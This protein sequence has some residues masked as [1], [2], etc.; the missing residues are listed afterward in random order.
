MKLNAVSLGVFLVG[1]CF[2]GEALAVFPPARCRQPR[3]RRA[4]DAGVRSG[5]SLVESAWNAVNDCDQVERFAD[6]VMNNLDSIDIPRESSDY[7]LCRVAGIV[8]GAEEVVDH[9]WN[10]CDWEC[11]KEGELMA[12]IGGKLYCD[13]SISLGGLGLA[14]DI[15]RLPVRT[16]GL[17]FQIGCDAEFIGYTQNYP[18]CGQFT[19]DPFTPVWNQTR[20]NQ[21]VYN[22]AP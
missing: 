16:C 12:R 3:E 9:T 2:A 18:M 15:I 6:L 22:P 4:F 19:R 7:V 10:R 5:A 1:L 13:L 21:C 20:N 14:S 17:A 8:Q 11:R